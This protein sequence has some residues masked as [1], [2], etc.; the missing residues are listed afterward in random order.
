MKSNINQLIQELEPQFK[1]QLQ[2]YLEY[3]LF[4]QKSKKKSKDV[5]KTKKE[6]NLLELQQFKGNAPFPNIII[7]EHEL[8]E[9]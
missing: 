9:N 1:S 7:S 2:D 6:S 8:Y 5:L 3:L 4:L